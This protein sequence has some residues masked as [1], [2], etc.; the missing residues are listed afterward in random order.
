MRTRTIAATVMTVAIGFLPGCAQ[1]PAPVKEQPAPTPGFAAV[2]GQKGGQ[3][4]TGPYDVV[5]NW[6]KHLSQCQDAS[7]LPRQRGF[8]QRSLLAWAWQLLPSGCW[9]PSSPVAK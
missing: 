2:A 4:Q 7:G 1:A 5:E 9:R 6:P 8:G 3:D